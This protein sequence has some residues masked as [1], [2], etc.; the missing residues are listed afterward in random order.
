MRVAA[1]TLHPSLKS[2]SPGDGGRQDSL[3]PTVYVE[4]AQGFDTVG[5]A[6]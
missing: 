1:G 5:Y 6:S 4:D 3:Y 2:G